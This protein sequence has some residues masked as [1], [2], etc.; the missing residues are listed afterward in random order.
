MESLTKN[1]QDED[2]IRAMTDKYFA[3]DG[4]KECRE[5]TAIHIETG[6]LNRRINSIKGPY[7][8]LPGQPEIQGEDWFFVFYRMFEL[9]VM[10]ARKRNID[11][12]ISKDAML[13]LLWRDREIFKEVAEPSLVHWDLWDGNVFV[14]NGKI[15]GLIDWERSVYGDPLME[16][17]FRT[18]KKDISFQKGYGMETLTGSCLKRAVWY[19][20]YLTMLIA[21]E[22]EYRNYETK[23]S[24]DWA[25]GI[26][27]KQVGK[28]MAGS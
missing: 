23:D 1:R 5:L 15:T 14:K 24:Y 18:Y 6:R 27:E 25:V 7:F 13:G 16:V 26:L 10:D 28:L 21:L 8:G 4:L 12:K 2:T 9:G 20:V 3:P 17:G 22:Y 11:L 19:D